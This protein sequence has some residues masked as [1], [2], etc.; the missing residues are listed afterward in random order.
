MIADIR[1]YLCIVLLKWIVAILP[2]NDEGMELLV[3]IYGYLKTS[4]LNESM[5]NE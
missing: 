3:H 4:I 5:L 2:N 1:M